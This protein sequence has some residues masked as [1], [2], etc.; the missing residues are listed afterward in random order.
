MTSRLTVHTAIVGLVL[1]LGPAFAVA[2]D[3]ISLQEIMQGLRDDLAQ[4]SDGLLTDDFEQIAQGADAIANHPRIPA[5]EVQLVAAELGVEMPAFKAIDT[6]VHDLAVEVAAAA[7][8]RDRDAVA[9]GYQR[10]F[11]GCL[12]CHGAYKERVAAALALGR[13]DSADRTEATPD[14]GRV[15]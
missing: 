7:R 12:A 4:V 3:E 13:R 1:S 15:H 14:S 2:S 9:A 11:E 6:R 5:Q 10:M 8:L